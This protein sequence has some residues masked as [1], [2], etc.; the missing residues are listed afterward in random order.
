MSKKTNE[1]LI[2][3]A[4]AEVSAIFA[5]DLATEEIKKA[6]PPKKEDNSDSSLN[7]DSVAS[8]D[9][10]KEPEPLPVPPP[11]AVAAEKEEEKEKVPEEPAPEQEMELSPEALQSEYAKLPAEEL[12][13]HFEAIQM[14]MEAQKPEPAP[15]PMAAEEK[16]M[17]QMM[18]SDEKKDEKSKKYEEM[19]KS[20]DSKL[21]KLE[22]MQSDLMRQE[23]TFKAALDKLA[24]SAS[25]VERKSI[26]STMEMGDLKKTVSPQSVDVGF[27]NQLVELQKSSTTTEKDRSLIL[28]FLNNEKPADALYHLFKK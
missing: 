9:E 5:K 15:M 20:L 6:A 14:V 4:I 17:P 21:A 26:S 24:K 3:N 11:P 19:E 27:I 22:A 13:M 8:L 16:A 28:S 2:K 12:K 7:S 18:K 25:I 23:T 1:Q 10:Q